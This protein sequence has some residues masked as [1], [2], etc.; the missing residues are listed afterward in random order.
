MGHV[1]Y[2]VIKQGHLTKKGHKVRSMKE[3]WL[4]LKPG[5]LSYY[6]SRACTDK[7]GE[8][9]IN[10]TTQVEIE[11]DKGKCRFII[12]CGGDKKTTYEM[13]AK[14]QRTRQEWVT[15]IQIAIGKCKPSAPCYTLRQCLHEKKWPRDPSH[16]PVRV[17]APGHAN[18]LIH[19][20]I[21]RREQQLTWQVMQ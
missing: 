10:K 4:I 13:E 11:S 14:D 17:T 19:F 15:A 2:N 6:T 21:N 3:R 1:V 9:L 16:P 5:N 7:K 18:Y 12:T 20:F 8:I